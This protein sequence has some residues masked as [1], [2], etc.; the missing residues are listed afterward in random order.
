MI[1]I[2]VTD[3]ITRKVTRIFIGC[4]DLATEMA[5]FLTRMGDIDMEEVTP[6][7]ARA[8]TQARKRKETIR[9]NAM[10]DLFIATINK[11][12]H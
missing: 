3:V 2:I 5:M 10:V 6:I 7:Q 11:E 1:K 9:A 12:V 4:A 8:E